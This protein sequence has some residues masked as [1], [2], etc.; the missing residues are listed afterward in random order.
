[1]KAIVPVFL[2]PIIDDIRNKIFYTPY[3]GELSRKTS[4]G[5]IIPAGCKDKNGYI[6]IWFN[7]RS[8]LAHR[9]AWAL[10]YNEEPPPVIDHGDHDKHN[11][12]I[13][14]LNGGSHKDNLYNQK[15]SSNSSTGYNGVSFRK[16]RNKYAAYVHVNGK[17]KNL[18]TFDSINDAVSARD[19]ADKKYNFHYNHGIKL[20]N[21]KLSGCH[22]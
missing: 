13:N 12:R 20:D 19:F 3:T 5:K 2:M 11:N 16:D 6:K 1:L 18:G 10:Y 4:T 17:K 21:E 14:N 22:S 9:L 8:Y 7:G 15:L